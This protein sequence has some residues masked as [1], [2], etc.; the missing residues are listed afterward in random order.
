MRPC[1]SAPPPRI[2][3]LG[4]R[5]VWGGVGLKGGGGREIANR[6]RALRPTRPRTEGDIGVCDQEGGEI[7]R[8][9]VGVLDHLQGYL[10]H[11]KQPPPRQLPP[12]GGAR[13]PTGV[14]RL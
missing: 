14:P 2:G 12:R 11:K 8:I 7:Q 9:R 13:P 1:P 5:P 10:A 6:L 3:D 4:F